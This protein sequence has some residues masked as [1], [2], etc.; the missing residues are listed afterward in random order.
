[1]AN[2]AVVQ[3]YL[4]TALRNKCTDVLRSQQRPEEPFGL[5][6]DPPDPLPDPR[7]IADEPWDTI[8]DA[9]CLMRDPY[10][11]VIVKLYLEG[12]RNADLAHEMQVSEDTVA[13]WKRRGLVIL[14]GLVQ[15]GAIPGS[16]ARDA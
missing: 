10:R 3:A 14:R 5:P 11:A 9:L 4:L 2:A 13:S 15:A 16:S 7:N 6:E 1:M 12:Y 8:N